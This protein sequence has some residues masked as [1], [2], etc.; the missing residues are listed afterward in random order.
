MRRGLA[1]SRHQA[2]EL[3]DRGIVRVG[4]SIA[5]KAARLVAESDPVVIESTVRRF[6]SRGGEKLDAA[7][8]R[9]AIEV[10]GKRCLDAGTSTGGFCDCLLQHGAASVVAVDV[11]H[12]VI[13]QRLRGDPRVKL[14][15][16]TNVRRLDLESTGGS[17]FE[18]VTADLSFISLTA[19][20]DVLARRLPLPGADLILLVKPQYEVGRRAASRGRGVV[21]DL[22]ERRGALERVSSALSAAGADVVGATASPLLGPAGN[23]EFF[24]H[25]HALADESPS[26]AQQASW[27]KLLDE[28]IAQSPDIDP[29][30]CETLSEEDD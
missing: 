9:F 27:A 12:G 25:A 15:E 5:D 14:L 1:P 19:T 23:A 2:A 6:V 20:L 22:S 24:L 7:L 8:E 18:I 10:R 26:G 29:V 16:R 11:A 28:A 13:H 17:R 21:K 4:G 30:S 3:I